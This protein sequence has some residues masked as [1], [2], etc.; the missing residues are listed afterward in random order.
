MLF[1]ELC[2]IMAFNKKS[3]LFSVIFYLCNSFYKNIYIQKQY[4]YII[5]FKKYIYF[6]LKM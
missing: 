6:R 4:M 1:C 3:T 2:L 5:L